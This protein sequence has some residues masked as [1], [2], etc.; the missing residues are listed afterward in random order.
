MTKHCDEIRDLLVDY[1]DGD[2][3]P[4]ESEMVRLHLGECKRCRLQ[5]AALDRSLELARRTWAEQAAPRQRMPRPRLAWGKLAA[6]AGC[7]AIALT[8]GFM[9]LI[10]PHQAPVGKKPQLMTFEQ[11]RLQV[12]REEAASRLLMSASELMEVPEGRQQAVEIIAGISKDYG[13][14]AAGRTAR[15]VK[16]NL[17]ETQ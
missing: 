5:L 15:N 16:P 8:L 17:G 10:P 3:P 2:L 7:L 13:D 6:M 9:A 11:V 14:T 1:A 12:Q 4:V